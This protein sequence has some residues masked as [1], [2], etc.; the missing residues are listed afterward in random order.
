MSLSW[1]KCPHAAKTTWTYLNSEFVRFSAMQV[2]GSYIW[3][4]P[5]IFET[6]INSFAFSEPKKHH[7]VC[8]T[9]KNKQQLLRQNYFR[10]CHHQLLSWQVPKSER[11]PSASKDSFKT[12][13]CSFSCVC[14]HFWTKWV[15]NSFSSA[16]FALIPEKWLWPLEYPFKMFAIYI[17]LKYVVQDL[18]LASKGNFLLNFTCTL[19]HKPKS[20]DKQEKQMRLRSKSNRDVSFLKRLLCSQWPDNLKIK[21]IQSYLSK[22]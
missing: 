20:N 6:K 22:L 17:N 7:F 1:T 14:K 21:R 10:P 4:C 2:S 18:L 5:I 11:F 19:L 8:K 13:F 12:T 15:T 16:N 9:T 3:I